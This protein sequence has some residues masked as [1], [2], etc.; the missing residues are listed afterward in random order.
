MTLPEIMDNLRGDGYRLTVSRKALLEILYSAD[1]P[2]SAQEL[3][4]ALTKKKI[5]VN[6]TTVYRELDFLHDK[7]LIEEVQFGKESM[8]RYEFA[9]GTHHHHIQCM[10]C[11]TVADV[12]MPDELKSASALIRKQTGFRVLE[13]SLEFSGLCDNC[14]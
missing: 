10:N 13:H 14:Q 6:K 12:D 5:T 8:K 4:A 2:L 1:T 7:E 11:G 9:L 3:L